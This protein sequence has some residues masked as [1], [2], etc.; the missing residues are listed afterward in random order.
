MFTIQVLTQTE[1]RGG[2]FFLF[3]FFCFFFFLDSVK[4]LHLLRFY[5]HDAGGVQTAV[6]PVLDSCCFDGQHF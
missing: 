5:H 1:V 2:F 6:G 4:D 3:F